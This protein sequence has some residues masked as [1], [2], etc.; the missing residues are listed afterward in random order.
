M[1]VANFFWYGKPISLY[2]EMSLK[3]FIQNGFEVIVWGY[4]PLDLPKGATLRYA[5]EILHPDHLFKY[6]QGGESRNLAAFS[7]VFRYNLLAQ[8]PGEWW[9]D[10]DCICV[11]QAYEFAQ[12]KQNKKFVAAWEDPDKRSANCAAI[13]MPDKKFAEDL[14][15]KQKHICDTVSDIPWAG[16]GPRLLTSHCIDTGLA[17]EILS[18]DAFYPIGYWET[19]KFYDPEEKQNT[20]KKCKESYIVHLWNEILSREGIDKTVWP[21]EDSYLY[22]L[23]KIINEY[24]NS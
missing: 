17:D 20:V 15:I 16:I 21:N 6:T 4:M 3:S 8:K 22:E 2:E 1:E 18:M 19:N 12:L 11:K 7:D 13:T 9:F 5:G 10:I 24:G 23:F 14:V